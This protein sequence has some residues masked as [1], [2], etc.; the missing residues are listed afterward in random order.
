MKRVDIIQFLDQIRAAWPEVSG[1]KGLGKGVVIIAPKSWEDRETQP[2]PA[3]DIN[4]AAEVCRRSMPRMW[5]M[6][7]PMPGTAD[8]GLVI[9]DQDG[10]KLACVCEHNPHTASW[11]EPRPVKE[12][13]NWHPAWQI[14]SLATQLFY[15]LNPNSNGKRK[16]AR[17]AANT[18]SGTSTS[19]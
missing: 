14:A 3:C 13:D 4:E 1:L 19:T 16:H 11:Y 6:L 18:G 5:A 15:P 10:H 12:A 2:G 8:L 17:R 7:M 9:G